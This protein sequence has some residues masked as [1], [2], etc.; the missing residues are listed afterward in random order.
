LAMV[1]GTWYAP[2]NHWKRTVTRTQL[3]Y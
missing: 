2:A 3:V 1:T